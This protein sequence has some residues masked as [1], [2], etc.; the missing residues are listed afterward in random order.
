[1][2]TM[3]AYGIPQAQIADVLGI[4][5][6]VLA[7]TFVVE[8]REAVP[9]ANAAVA[10]ALFTKA[11][12]DGPQSATAAI[13]WLKARA[14]WRETSVVEHSGAIE[15]RQALDLSSL[16]RDERAALRGLL[17]QRELAGTIDLEASEAESLEDEGADDA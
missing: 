4:S 1:M 8:R 15:M 10:Q 14:G 5:E 7:K 3:T 9:L 6:A 17:A 12:G 11:T 13:F 2:R 16:S